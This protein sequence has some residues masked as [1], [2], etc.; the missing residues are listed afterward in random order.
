MLLPPDRAAYG[1]A[2][3]LLAGIALV[4]AF[5][6]QA[7]PPHGAADRRTPVEVHFV[8]WGRRCDA[9]DPDFLIEARRKIERYEIFT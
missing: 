7:P 5:G 6:A 9:V 3:K 4:L 2:M 8:S 1:S